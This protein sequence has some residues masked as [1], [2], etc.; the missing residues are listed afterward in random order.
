MSR[1]Q[2]IETRL[3][4][5]RFEVQKVSVHRPA[6]GMV[7]QRDVVRHPGA[8]V[9]LPQ[10]DDGRFCF[11]KSYRIAVNAELIELP[12]GTRESNEAPIETARRELE[13]E[14]GY[15]CSQLEP[16]GEFC[17]SPGILDEQMHAFVAR[18][19]TEGAPALEPG[20]EI[21]NLLLTPVEVQELI[22]TNKIQDAKTLAVLTLF[23]AKT[24]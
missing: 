24:D 9:I 3:V 8:V 1:K 23:Q 18:G 11:I 13:E 4:C 6:D 19:L 2:Q 10:L 5:D 15:R 14:T 12:A 20:E 7:T 22:A 21:I 17:M 16:L